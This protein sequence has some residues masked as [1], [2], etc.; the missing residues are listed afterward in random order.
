M[1]RQADAGANLA[2]LIGRG[3]VQGGSPAPA[4]TLDGPRPGALEG[5]SADLIRLS[6]LGPVRAWHGDS[7]IDLGPPQQRAILALLLVKAG[8]PASMVELISLLWPHDPPV[9][10]ANVIQRCIGAL[11]RALEPGL[12]PRSNGRW[13]IRQGGGYRL[14]LDGASLDLRQFRALAKQGR[15]ALEGERPADAVPLFVQAL[16][17]WRGQCA[18]GIEADSLF[19]AVD[20][21]RLIVAQE[22]ADSALRF[23]GARLL[24]PALRQAGAGAQLDEPLQARLMLVLAAAGYQ[25]EALGIYQTVTRQ[26]ADDLGMDP[27]QELREAYQK[28]LRQQAT[29]DLPSHQSAPNDNGT[30]S[31]H[32]AI[33]HLTTAG[34]AAL[35]G[36][37]LPTNGSAAPTPSPALAAPDSNATK[38]VSGQSSDEESPAPLVP[39]AQLPADLPTFTG[40]RAE[41]DRLHGLLE[42]TERGPASVR[43]VAIDGMAGI[44]KTTLAI[45]LAHQV[46]QRYPDGQLYLNLRGFDSSGTAMTA[47]EALRIFLDALGI[48]PQR[49]PVEVEAQAALYRSMLHGRKVLVLL[50][51]ARDV[52]QIR[53]LLP[54]AAGCLVIITSRNQLTGLITT[55]AAYPLTVES[56]SAQDARATLT[57]RLD[58][59]RLADDSAALDEIVELCAGLPLAVAIVAAR[60]TVHYYLPIAAIAGELRDARTR[61]DA[62]SANDPATDMRAVFSW[63][64]ELLSPQAAR[65]FRLLSLHSGPDIAL[66]AMAGLLGRPEPDTRRLVTELTRARLITEHHPHRFSMHDLIR[67]YAAELAAELDTEADRTEARRRLFD[68]YLHSAYRANSLLGPYFIPIELADPQAGVVPAELPSKQHAKAWLAAERHVLVATVRIAADSGFATHAWQLALIPQQFLQRQGY[69]HDWEAGA[70]LGLAAA[71]TAEDLTGQAHTRRSLAGALH[72]LGRNDE[73]LTELE[74]THRL[75]AELGYTTEHAYL[76]SNFGAVLAQ[77][78][79]Y[80]QAIEHHEQ[81]LRLY[82]EMAD[83]NGQAASLER[84]GGCLTRLGCY[85]EGIEFID[86]AMEIYRSLDNGIGQGD[87]WTA[88]G[89]THHLLG[90]YHQAADCHARAIAFFK[91]NGD[92][93]YEA[94]VLVALGDSWLAADYE[95]AAGEAWERALAI[96]DELRL[97]LANPVR[98]RLVR[99]HESLRHSPLPSTA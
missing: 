88:L 12:P 8:Q 58:P 9:S 7:E 42:P 30:H 24:L 56:F 41:L 17:L 36:N 55:H 59:Y 28:V 69:W 86:E 72:F 25:A 83:R 51:N 2:E 68:F 18:A 52:E 1:V 40:R 4:R 62:F 81:A 16:Q 92:R 57:Q 21:E 90:E 73:A 15:N 63:S 35:A 82:S 44:G 70:R 93:T 85:P 38:A 84:I 3:D 49:I 47:S 13:L 19:R 29:P 97:P 27:T 71:V 67:V 96:L 98:T 74:A 76:H 10:A 23:G 14:A 48:A 37:Q 61:L 33:N 91:E 80:E 54:A 11:R 60:A 31:A 5:H 26:L 95:T 75:F 77:Q 6:V 99:L 22:A 46:A 45:H 65:G 34:S 43:I 50:D 78:S 66:A 89:D 53:P 32:T 87:C 64:Y 20:Q 94:Q 39:L 79:R